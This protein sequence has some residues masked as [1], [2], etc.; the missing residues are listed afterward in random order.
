[1]ISNKEKLGEWRLNNNITYYMEHNEYAVLLYHDE[2]NFTGRIKYKTDSKGNVEVQFEISHEVKQRGEMLTTGHLWW[3]KTYREP[4]KIKTKRLW[5]YDWS[6]EFYT[7]P[8]E[9]IYGC[10][11]S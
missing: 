11:N 5:I 7:Y 6:L 9:V 10:T 1:M 8:V 3:K 2:Y 4:D